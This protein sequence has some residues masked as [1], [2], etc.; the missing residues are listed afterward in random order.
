MTRARTV[1]WRQKS[2][3]LRGVTMAAVA[4][5]SA[6]IVGLVTVGVVEWRAGGQPLIADAVY[7]HPHHL[8]GAVRFISDAQ[9]HVLAIA[10]PL[11]LGTALLAALL[12]L[13]IRRLEMKAAR[14]RL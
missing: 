7:R 1:P 8:R 4:A 3:A 9:E 10:T 5:W 13:V 6:A 2:R 11:T 14:D 12:A